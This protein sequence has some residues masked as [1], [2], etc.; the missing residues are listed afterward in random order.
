MSRITAYKT[1]IASHFEYC[2]KM[3]FYLNKGIIYNQ[4]KKCYNIEQWE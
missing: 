1:S 4:Y 2:P 3:M